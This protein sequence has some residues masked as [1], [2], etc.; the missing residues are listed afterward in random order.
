MSHS[1]RHGEA[2]SVAPASAAAAIQRVF[3]ITLILNVAVA[4]TKATYGWLSG[5]IAIGSDAVH[6]VLDGSSNVLALLSLR[7][8]SAPA[9]DRHPYGRQKIEILAAVGIGTLIVF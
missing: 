6:A 2:H 7:W 9:D 8:A 1:H 4:A 5:S 3:V